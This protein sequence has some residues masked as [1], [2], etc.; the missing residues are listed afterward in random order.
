M[1]GV[2]M[3]NGIP[4]EQSM[5]NEEKYTSRELSKQLKEAGAK[6]ESE[7]CYIMVGD[8]PAALEWEIA[9][10]HKSCRGGKEELIATFD[11]FELLERMPS[12]ADV[13]TAKG[14]FECRLY[15]TKDDKI[16][17]SYSFF[18]WHEGT[19]GAFSFGRD[20][21]PAEALGKLYLWCLK[22]GHCSE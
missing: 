19:Q 1:I 4:G 18:Y 20:N 12:W 9:E 10:A 22:E 2:F 8:T 13:D 17:P 21:T 6:Q 15:M 3:W 11:C 14:R 7:K 16:D 5:T